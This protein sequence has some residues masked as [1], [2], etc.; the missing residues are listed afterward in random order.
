MV[1]ERWA[2]K[3]KKYIAKRDV[4][5]YKMQLD[6]IFGIDSNPEI[7]RLYIEEMGWD[8]LDY[9]IE[10]LNYIIKELCSKKPKGKE[11]RENPLDKEEQDDR[12]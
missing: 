5:N 2:M 9:E 8:Y 4:R 3:K 1:S 11:G 10:R 7:V 12:S 6:K